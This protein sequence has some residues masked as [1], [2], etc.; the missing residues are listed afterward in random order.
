MGSAKKG[1]DVVARS[2]RQQPW[3]RAARPPAAPRP[4]AT[5]IASPDCV[6]SSERDPHNGGTRRE[7]KTA[8]SQTLSGQHDEAGPRE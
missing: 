8:R 5:H 6:A 7:N 4:V 2:A 3:A 1:V